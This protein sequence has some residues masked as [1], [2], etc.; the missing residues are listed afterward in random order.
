MNWK[1]AHI[2]KIS[3]Y[4]I[5]LSSPLNID[6]SNNLIVIS[7]IFVRLVF[8]NFVISLLYNHFYSNELL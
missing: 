6:G 5:A 3:G 4:L 1:K 8:V 7:V 2:L